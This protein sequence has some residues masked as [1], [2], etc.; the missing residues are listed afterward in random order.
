MAMT[1]GASL[2]ATINEETLQP[3][4][5][6]YRAQTGRPT[7][8]NEMIAAEIL[9]RLSNGES[10]RSICKA[11]HL[12]DFSTVYDWM[13]RRP[14]FAHTVAAARTIQATALVEEAQEIVDTAD[15]ASMAHVQKADKQAQFRKWRATC[16]DREQYGDKVQ[17]DVNVRG[18]V[19][20]TDNTELARLMNGE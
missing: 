15:T 8:F 16:Q 6:A 9:V 18:V 4:V 5:E 3:F 14:E 10:M 12:P 7:I 19:I 13:R 11:D 2:P 20:H 17:Q 1:T